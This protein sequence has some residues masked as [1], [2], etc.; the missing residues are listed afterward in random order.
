[1]MPAQ[2]HRNIYCFDTSAF[3]TLGR[4]HEK[5]IELPASLWDHLEKMMRDGQIISH[6][7][8]FDEISSDIKD[9]DF[10]AQ[11][12]ADKK[13][14]FLER[15]SAQI[16]MV[17]NIVSRCPD[18]IDYQ[19]EHEQA[20]PWLI[21]LAIEKSKEQTLFYVNVSSKVVSQ[22]S[23]NSPK[24]I[25]AACKYFGIQHRSLREFFDEMGLSTELSKNE[26]FL[27][28]KKLGK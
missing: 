18:L 14:C 25:P 9:P 19:R 28:N 8:V 7:L 4:T 22:E 11:W 10:V 26:N 15:T 17:P 12:I 16:S 13:A 2:K 21:A 20:D 27:A 1:M 23:S 24:K 6:R 3:I 5:V